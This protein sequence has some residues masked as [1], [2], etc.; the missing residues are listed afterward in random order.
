MNESCMDETLKLIMY[1][2]Q[3]DK[4]AL[5][6]LIEDNK[7]LIWSIVRR[8]SNR[9]H[10][11]EDLFQIGSI[12]LIKAINKFD[13]SFNVRLS[14][15]AVPVI[16]GEIKR[17]LRDDGIIKV[18]RSIKET[19]YKAKKTEEQMRKELGRQ[20]TISEIASRMGIDVEE[21]AM[22]FDA[23]TMP[24]S[25]YDNINADNSNPIL[26]IDKFD[27]EAEHQPADIV[28]KIALRQLLAKLPPKEKQII[29]LRYFREKT[30]TQVAEML[31]ISQVQVSRIE[32][33]IIKNL[34]QNM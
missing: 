18:S 14:T 10:E 17:F 2:K 6:K 30:Q 32:K 12:G 27:A 1:A 26:L 19:A 20:P 29:L 24:K 33:R 25:L 9:G 5:S 16:M 28:D 34:R 8:F 22:S 7:G 4:D 11:I 21:L 31:G 13:C 23:V 15:Y 3:G